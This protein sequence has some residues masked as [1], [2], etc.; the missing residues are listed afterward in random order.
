MKTKIQKWGNSQGLRLSKEL[1]SGVDLDVGDEV[2]VE[3]HEGSLVITPSN[4]IRGKYDLKDL[5]Q[6][7]PK[8]YRP[9]EVNWGKPSGKEAW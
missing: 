1:L 2:E 7:I 3:A 4:K 5:V 8:D 6:Q 9:E